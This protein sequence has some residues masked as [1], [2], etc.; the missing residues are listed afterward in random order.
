MSNLLL[1]VQS[2]VF[3]VFIVVGILIVLAAIKSLL[4]KRM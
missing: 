3:T 2:T 1:A 4:I